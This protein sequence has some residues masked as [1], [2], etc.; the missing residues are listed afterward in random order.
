MSAFAAVMITGPRAVGKT[1]TA[2]RLVAQVDRLDIPDVATS[3]RLDPDAA[4]R[5]AARPLLID[6]WQEV[7]EV[8]AAVKRAVDTDREP[9]QFLLSG[10]VR[11]TLDIATWAG[12]GRVIRIGM[13]PVTEREQLGVAKGEPVLAWV[14]E[15][16][17][18]MPIY[19]R[20]WRVWQS[21][22]EARSY[23]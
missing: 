11:A 3:Y 21:G 18:K 9:G 13:L 16:D 17:N 12:T 20:P 2:A 19:R 7:P 1:T 15:F 22:Y 8:L 23:R 6:E 5:R 14:E 4:L 10:S